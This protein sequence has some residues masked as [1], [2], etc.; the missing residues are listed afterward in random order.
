MKEIRVLVAC[1][2]GVATSAVVGSKVKDLLEANGYMAKVELRKV[3]EVEGIASD[4]DL[5]VASTRCPETG[6]PTVFAISYLT[7]VGTEAT[8]AQIL[9]AA[10]KLDL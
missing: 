8:D 5:I 3:T 2:S 4:Y 9:E 7:G 1:G 10:S 6:T